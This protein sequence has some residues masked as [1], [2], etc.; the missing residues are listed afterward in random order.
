MRE[1]Y[2][3]INNPDFTKFKFV[4]GGVEKNE[5]KKALDEIYKKIVDPTN[6]NKL[7]LVDGENLYNRLKNT[8]RG[9]GGSNKRSPDEAL[10]DY[11]EILKQLQTLGS[12]HTIVVASHE[13]LFEKLSE[14]YVKTLINLNMI[15]IGDKGEQDDYLLVLIASM[16]K[17]RSDF[18]NRNYIKQ[19]KPDIT[20]EGNQEVFDV[21]KYIG[22][23]KFNDPNTKIYFLT[24]DGYRFLLSENVYTDRNLQSQPKPL[25]A[26]NKGFERLE[27]YIDTNRIVFRNVNAAELQTKI[28]SLKTLKNEYFF[29]EEEIDLIPIKDFRAFIKKNVLGVTNI[30]DVIEAL[31]K[32]LNKETTNKLELQIITDIKNIK[33]VTIDKLTLL[34]SSLLLK[35]QSIKELIS[36]PQ[37]S[38]YLDLA[39][40]GNKNFQTEDN[41]YLSGGGKKKVKK[42]VK[43]KLLKDLLEETTPNFNLI[44]NK[45]NYL[46]EKFHEEKKGIKDY[47]GSLDTKLGSDEAK[48]YYKLFN[49]DP[50]SEIKIVKFIELLI[51]NTEKVYHAHIDKIINSIHYA[52][53]IGTNYILIGN[54]ISRNNI[55]TKLQELYAE[56]P[57]YNVTKKRETLNEKQ[58]LLDNIESF[59]GRPYDMDVDKGKLQDIKVANDTAL[60]KLVSDKINDELIV[61]IN[62]LFEGLEVDELLKLILYL[63]D[64]KYYDDL[65]DSTIGKYLN[66]QYITN[67]T[68]VLEGETKLGDKNILLTLYNMYDYKFKQAREI[69]LSKTRRGSGVSSQANNT[70]ASKEK[71][72]GV[73]TYGGRDNGFRSRYKAFIESIYLLNKPEKSD[74]SF[75]YLI[76]LKINDKHY[77]D[78]SRTGQVSAEGGGYLKNSPRTKKINTRKTSNKNSTK[79]LN[80]F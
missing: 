35:Y 64:R 57:D 62:K 42:N 43:N 47:T 40:G 3:A 60:N 6:T 56:F 7:I 78:V 61:R 70:T 48:Q 37:N 74:T 24:H 54:E 65:Y 11:K 55:H 36:I 20:T 19:L 67:P 51:G 59:L 1:L 30:N 49:P 52:S 34:R 5:L 13:Y 28:N 29:R 38:A 75:P 21:R 16:I 22:K 77:S 68:E 31:R 12:T 14:D 27:E 32:T 53:V 2:N 73:Y 72:S 44:L 63:L 9:T 10:E 26:S 46:R 15:F 39:G 71:K 58:Q 17:N 8:K 18:K 69:D 33:D 80:K 45:L 4:S 50:D 25:G 41:N 76:F 66:K 79:K 23:L